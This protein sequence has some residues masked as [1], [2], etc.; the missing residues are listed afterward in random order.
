MLIN[1]ASKGEN[2]EKVKVNFLVWK[3]AQI[4]SAIVLVIFHE[5]RMYA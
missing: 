1:I 5:K 4:E 3:D 2:L